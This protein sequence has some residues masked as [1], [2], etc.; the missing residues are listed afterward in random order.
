MAC[1]TLSGELT[2]INNNDKLSGFTDSN[3]VALQV[4]GKVILMS[5]MKLYMIIYNK[6]RV[7]TIDDGSDCSDNYQ[8]T[9]F[10]ENWA[11]VSG[12]H[13]TINYRLCKLIEFSY[14]HDIFFYDGSNYI[15]YAAEDMM[16]R[17]RFGF[18]HTIDDSYGVSKIL[19]YHCYCLGQTSNPFIICKCDNDLILFYEII[20]S[21]YW[22]RMKIDFDANS[23]NKFVDYIMID[24]LGQAYY[25]DTKNIETDNDIFIKISNNNFFIDAT[26]AG[27]KYY[28][29]DDK[30]NIYTLVENT[31]DTKL[32]KTEC[33][34]KRVITPIKSANNVVK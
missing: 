20:K 25:I 8:V 3:F 23:I 22:K 30:N 11:T 12:C 31:L 2:Y 24:N 16:F 7:L 21:L 18:A 26:T 5:D 9:N 27:G 32:I 6:L 14:Q 34:F 17:D 19:H 15:W 4:C 1:I 13:Y 33:T 29:Q 28:L 10:N